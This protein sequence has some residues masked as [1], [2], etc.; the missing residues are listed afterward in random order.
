MLS[1]ENIVSSN[2]NSCSSSKD[3]THGFVA[4][5]I[6]KKGRINSNDLDFNQD[7]C[8]DDSKENILGEFNSNNHSNFDI[9]IV[10]FENFK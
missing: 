7:F 8:Q 5:P 10:N 9:N 1:Y 3:L 6:R 4:S 2:E